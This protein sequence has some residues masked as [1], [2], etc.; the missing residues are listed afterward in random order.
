LIFEKRLGV[1]LPAD[2]FPHWSVGELDTVTLQ[3]RVRCRLSSTPNVVGRR[4]LKA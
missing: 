3:G 2:A 1:A 4:C